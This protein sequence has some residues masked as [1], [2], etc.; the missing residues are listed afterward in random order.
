MY[1]KVIPFTVIGEIMAKQDLQ[2]EERNCSLV[3]VDIQF[4][5]GHY[6]NVGYKPEENGTRESATLKFLLW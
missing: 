1:F 3:V 6:G 4:I 5:M 2:E